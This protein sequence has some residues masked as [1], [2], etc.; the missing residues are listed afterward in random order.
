M[1]IFMLVIKKDKKSKQPSAEVINIL[2]DICHIGLENR[3]ITYHT[4]DETY[5]QISTF[6]EISTLLEQYGF[7][8]VDRGNLVNLKKI[9][10]LDTEYSRVF[11]DDH[12]T[13]ESKF[14]TV[15]ATHLRR[16]KKYLEERKKQAEEPGEK[17]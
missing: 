3:T 9:T 1:E 4:K 14:A 8:T 17:E 2:D 15:S 10:K 16:I 6:E 12:I 5:Y 7:T 11:F 13:K